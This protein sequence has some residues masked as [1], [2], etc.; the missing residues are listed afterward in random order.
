MKFAAHAPIYPG[1]CWMFTQWV[2]GE[3]TPMRKL[4]Y[5]PNFAKTLTGASV[6]IF[7]AG[8]LADK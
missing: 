4:P 3:T 5:P 2:K 6:K 7:A 1:N 8:K